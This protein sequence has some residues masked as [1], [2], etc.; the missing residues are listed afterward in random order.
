MISFINKVATKVQNTRQFSYISLIYS[1][2]LP[3]LWYFKGTKYT[4]LLSYQKF[5]PLVPLKG[6]ENTS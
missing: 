1:M 4:L 2:E 3:Y 5:I 6:R